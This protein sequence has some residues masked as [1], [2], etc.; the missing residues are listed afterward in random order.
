MFKKEELKENILS[1]WKILNNCKESFLFCKYLHLPETSNEKQYIE[2]SRYFKYIRHILWRNS[3]I[4]LSKL[5]SIS[6]NRDKYNISHFIKKLKPQGHFKI[7]KIDSHKIYDWESTFA[8]NNGII[9]NLLILRDKVYA[10]TDVLDANESLNGLTF[11]EMEMLINLVEDLIRE[12]Y[13]SVF[14]GDVDLRTPLFGRG[15]FKLINNLIEHKEFKTKELNERL[16]SK[17]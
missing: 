8:T 16:N 2:N 6:K 10:H 15:N 12:I 4:E 11:E 17:K 3:V 9:D 14:N 5:F 1:I 13:R 7:F